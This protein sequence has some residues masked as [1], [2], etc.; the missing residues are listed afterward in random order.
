[1]MIVQTSKTSYALVL[2]LRAQS[3]LIKELLSEGYDFVMTSR[4]QSE[5]SGSDSERIIRWQ[6][7]TS[8][9]KILV[10][11][12]HLLIFLLFLLNRTLDSNS[13][14]VSTTIAGYVAKKLAKRSNCDSCKSLLIA[15]SMDLAE[16]H[17]LNLLSR[18]GLIV[19]S[20][21][22][23]EYTSHCFAI[24]DYSY[25][26]VQAHGVRDVRAAYTQIF[27]RFS[28]QI[29]ICCSKHNNWGLKF[30]AKIVINTFFNNKQTVSSDSARKDT[31]VAFKKRQRTK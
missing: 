15:S 10:L 2:T 17:Y 30:A 21:K 1:M 26:I 11:T 14:E 8:G 31:V 22:L 7:L 29:D 6:T 3:G 4:L 24:M 28:P 25:N 20:A 19:P 27:D 18:G 13:E 16:N 23:A 12:N 9:K 5:P